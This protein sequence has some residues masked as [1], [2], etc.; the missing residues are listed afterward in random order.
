MK[1]SILD[2]IEETTDEAMPKE[3]KK[4]CE[5]CEAD[6]NES[7]FCGKCEVDERASQVDEDLE[8]GEVNRNISKCKTCRGNFRPKTDDDKICPQCRKDA[9]FVKESSEDKK[10]LD[11]FIKCPKCHGEGEYEIGDSFGTYVCDEC[12]GDQ[13]VPRR[14]E[15]EVPL[16]RLRDFFPGRKPLK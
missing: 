2:I 16:Q 13:I 8:G 6:A 12:N 3:K 5:H 7:G 14:H 15:S 4:K 10:S 11:G 9:K 1:K